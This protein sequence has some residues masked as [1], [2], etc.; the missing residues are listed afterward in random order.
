MLDEKCCYDSDGSDKYDFTSEN[1]F[2][3]F[4]QAYQNAYTG[5]INQVEFNTL[6]TYYLKDILL[7]VI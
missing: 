2:L 3:I 5:T 1:I 6:F 4:P 7:R